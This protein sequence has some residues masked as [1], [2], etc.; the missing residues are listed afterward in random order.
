[1]KQPG[2][3][4]VISLSALLLVCSL[5]P[6]HALSQESVNLEGAGVASHPHI[7]FSSTLPSSTKTASPWPGSISSLFTYTIGKTAAPILSGPKLL[8][9]K[10]TRTGN[11]AW[12]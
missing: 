1:M 2:Y 9:C 3:L 12:T 10:L 8:P 4:H 11:I 5:W 7:R 6:L